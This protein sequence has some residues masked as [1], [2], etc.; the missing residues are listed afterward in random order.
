L[1]KL[2]CEHPTAQY[3]QIPWATSAPRRRECEAT[4]RGLS[5]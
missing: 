1:A 3:G 5:G 2:N 4:V